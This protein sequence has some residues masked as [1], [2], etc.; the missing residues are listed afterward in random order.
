MDL[1]AIGGQIPAALV[2]S[3]FV[4]VGNPMIVLI[5][6]GI[7][8]YPRRVGFL[9]GL[10]VA[11]ISEFSLI[12]VALGLEL[13]HIDQD[14]VGLVTL[15]GLITIG[16]STYLILY[17]HP[18]FERI[19]PL[20]AVFERQNVIDEPE[21]PS[22]CI[23]AVVF[24]YGRYGRSLV[25]RLM[26]GGWQVMVVDWDPYADD[27]DHP[28]LEVVYGDA[29]DAEFPGSLPL[30]RARWVVSTI[31]RPETNRQLLAALRHWDFAGH[32]ALTAHDEADVELLEAMDPSAVLRPFRDAAAVA[33]E[34]LLEE[35]LAES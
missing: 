23:D 4:L 13:G 16:L 1:V 19:A 18:I 6:M 2:L 26:A 15:V 35:R 17:S 5:I 24:G 32:V 30:D 14:T 10:A 11:Q 33:A 31:P 8:G 34:T 7:M 25:D 28:K 20:L 22:E 3:V 27:G 21:E 9:S 29:E 12:L